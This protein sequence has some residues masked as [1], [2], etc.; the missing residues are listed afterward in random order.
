M[1]DILKYKLPEEQED[2]VSPGDPSAMDIDPQL[3]GDHEAPSNDKLRSNL[4]LPPPPLFSR[5]EIPQ[6][7]RYAFPP[8]TN[9]SPIGC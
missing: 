2:Y 4:R 3:R 5:Q 6:I 8:V 7:Y 9:D 1:E